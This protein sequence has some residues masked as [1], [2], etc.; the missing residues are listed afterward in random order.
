MPNGLTYRAIRARHLLS[1]VFEHWL[2]GWINNFIPHFAECKFIFIHTGVEVNPFTF[3]KRGPWWL[4]DNRQAWYIGFFCGAGGGVGY[5]VSMLQ[6]I[7]DQPFILKTGHSRA[8]T[9]VIMWPRVIPLTL[10]QCTLECHWLI[11]CT[12]GYHW[13][14]QRILAG[15]TGN[16]V[17]TAHTGMP[18][19]KL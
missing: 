11:Q 14:T 1:H 16:L 10:S 5:F 2:W 6:I 9:P 19:G 13:A 15:Y 18:L 17:E 12:L 8:I 4:S 7:Y 3:T